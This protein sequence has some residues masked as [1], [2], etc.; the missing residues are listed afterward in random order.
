MVRVLITD[1]VRLIRH[2]NDDDVVAMVRALGE[3]PKDVRDRAGR[4]RNRGARSERAAPEAVRF[5]RTFIADS[6]AF[7]SK[8]HCRSRSILL[9]IPSDPFAMA[10]LGTE[11]FHSLFHFRAKRDAWRPGVF[12]GAFLGSGAARGWLGCWER[13]KFMMI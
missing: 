3:R 4:S 12:G 8:I 6:A 7:Y 5:I 2:G 1:T 11:A 9:G 10:S 13:I